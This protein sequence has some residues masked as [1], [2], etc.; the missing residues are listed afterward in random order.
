MD[1]EASQAISKFIFTAPVDPSIFVLR[2]YT[3]LVPLLPT[4]SEYIELSIYH[5][6]IVTGTCNLDAGVGDFDACEL[7]IAVSAF[8][9]HE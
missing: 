7:D 9:V 4:T 3:A 1:C 8:Q 2:V 6:D 5:L